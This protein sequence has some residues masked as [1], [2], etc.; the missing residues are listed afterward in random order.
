MSHLWGALYTTVNV[1]ALV[2]TAILRKNN[3]ETTLCDG[4]YPIQSK[5]EAVCIRLNEQEQERL[6]RGTGIIAGEKLKLMH[7]KVS[8]FGNIKRLIADPDSHIEV[9]Y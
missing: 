3:L 6:L 9:Y 1:S 2:C 4:S 8:I 5:N 7:F